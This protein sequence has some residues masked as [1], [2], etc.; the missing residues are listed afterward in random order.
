MM[1]VL[2]QWMP[3]LMQ[4]FPQFVDSIVQTLIMLLVVGGIF[5]LW[6]VLWCHSCRHQGR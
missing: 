1:E 6:I 5:D 3:N 2:N 4:M